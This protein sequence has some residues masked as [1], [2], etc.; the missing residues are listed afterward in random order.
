M[1]ITYLRSSSY[2]CHEM[3]PMKYFLE[4][5]LGWKGP[6]N[7]KAEKGTVVHKA[8][9]V[10]AIIKL[11]QQNGIETFEDDVVG[12]VNIFDYDLDD[13]IHKCTQ[14]YK[15]HSQ[16][17]WKHTGL[18]E[19]HCKQWTYKALE[20][21]DGEY[22][23]R[24]AHII[25]PEQAFD[26]TIH[27]PWAMYEY[28]L[29]NGEH[30]EGFFGIKGTIDQISQIDEETYQILDWKT[31]KRLNWATGQ[32]YDYASLQNNFQLMMYYYAISKIYPEIPNI[33]LVIYYINDGGPYTICF[34]KKDIPR[35][36]KRIQEKFEEIR[37]TEIPAL[38]KSWKCTGF[39]HYGRTTFENT[40]LLPI[41]ERR[42]GRV[43]KKGQPMTKCEQTRYC[44]EN[45]S[46]ESVVKNMSAEG[47]DVNKYDAPGE[48]KETSK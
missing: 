39:C 12:K 33:Q 8:L 14:Y 2:G 15:K 6:S 36:E 19:R 44:L 27:Q 32:E 22:D 34:S 24:N 30:I 5:G 1:I 10:L 23:P 9:E 21:N 38:K 18:D 31:G 29:P 37:D 7:I 43:T 3:C 25:Q 47:Y 46:V 16:N 48:I 40:S 11:N 26:I 35:I 28:D 42:N 20:Y 45:R 13:I 4:Y 41:I 17:E